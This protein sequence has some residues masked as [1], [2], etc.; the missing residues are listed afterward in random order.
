MKKSAA[1]KNATGIKKEYLLKN[2]IRGLGLKWVHRKCLPVT[3]GLMVLILATGFIQGTWYEQLTGENRAL[4]DYSP[5][6]IMDG[7]WHRIISSFPLTGDP[8]HL[9]TAVLMTLLCVGWLELL[10]GSAT[11][12][13]VFSGVHVST[14]IIK[15]LMLSRGLA[16]SSIPS[17]SW[18]IASH[19]VGPS[20][21]FYGCLGVCI[22]LLPKTMRVWF[23]FV[24]MVVLALRLII[25]I[26][27]ARRTDTLIRSDLA[28][29]IAFSL[30][31]AI[32]Y[33][34]V[35]RVEP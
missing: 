5:Q 7:A 1:I 12:L 22:F 16:W 3:L 18:R 24:I 30:G 33:S 27:S 4:F 32:A 20:A 29:L 15:G 2:C 19:V 31:I 9:G 26:G 28:H 6:H 10:Q 14:A 25:G 35:R 23:I 34:F 11:T 8:S 13:A 21:G 17:T